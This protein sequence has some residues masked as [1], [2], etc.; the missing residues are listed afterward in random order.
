M[1][2]FLGGASKF[3]RSVF[4]ASVLNKKIPLPFGEGKFSAPAQYDAILSTLYG[5]YMTL[6]PEEERKCKEHALLVDLNRDYTHYQNYR[7]HME[8]ETVTRSIR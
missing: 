8:F 1:H 3:S 5:D 7:D 6:P 2:C 4:P